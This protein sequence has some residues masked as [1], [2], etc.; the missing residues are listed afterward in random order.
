LIDLH[1]HT[2]ASDGRCSPAEL[3]ARASAA[4]VRVLSVTDHDTIAGYR[5]AAAACAEAQIVLVPGIEITAVRDGVDVHTLGYFI[6]VE[7]PALSRF[8]TAQRQD[9]LNRVHAIV[10]LLARHG[11]VLDAEAILAPARA[12]ANKS[13]GRP[14]VARAL[15]EAGHVASINEAFA[16]WLSRGQPAFVPRTGDTPERVIAHVH[17]AGGIASIAHPGTLAH[18]EWLPRFVDAGLD[19]IEAYH[20]DHDAPT[21]ARYLAFANRTGIAV[22]GGSDFHGN[23]SHGGGEPGAVSLPREALERLRALASTARSH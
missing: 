19:A 23:A 16:R 21:T 13:A 2:T 7:S 9:R 1:T 5:P 14:W 10:D 18:D 4:G 3:V 17:D 11:I 20:T 22:S 12:D 8:L 6:D 15:V